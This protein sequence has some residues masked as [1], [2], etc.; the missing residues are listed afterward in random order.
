VGLQRM[1]EQATIAV[2]NELGYGKLR[3][4]IDAAFETRE[5]EGFLRR[6]VKGKLSVRDYESVVGRGLLGR[7][8]SEI[9]A[10]LPVSDQAMIR[11]RYL[12]LV[13]EVPARLRQR[14]FKA[15][16]SY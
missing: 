11:E 5:V 8:A 16:V 2:K 3:A 1:F 6:V 7:D 10:G 9:Y 15:Y 4:L 13:E 14:Y 12:R